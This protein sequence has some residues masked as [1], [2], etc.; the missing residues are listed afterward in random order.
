MKTL[1]GTE[2]QVAWAEDIRKSYIDI[3]DTLK[4]AIVVLSDTTQEEITQRD[5]LGG[6]VT[7]KRYTA[8]LTSQQQAAIGI[9]EY[10]IRKDDQITRQEATG[11][12]AN[13]RSISDIYGFGHEH[14]DNYRL[15]SRDEVQAM[16]DTLTEAIE[17][18][19]CAKYWIDR[20]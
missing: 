10:F 7:T 1:V 12:W 15:E 20:R 9:A 16:L 11:E 2:K 5:P 17:N 6:A 18:Q 4:E 13:Q 14:K 3:V 8:Q 19:D